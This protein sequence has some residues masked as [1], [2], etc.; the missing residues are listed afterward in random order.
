VPVTGLSRAGHC[1]SP[2][3]AAAIAA[4]GVAVL[5]ASALAP[6]GGLF[7]LPADSDIEV[8]AA[9]AERTF[10]G[11]VPYR[12]F[13]LE[14]P[15]GALPVLLAP[16]TS[17]TD[18]YYTRFRLAMLALAAAAVVLL[19][20]ALFRVGADAA[21]LAAAVLVLA[22]V[23]RTLTPGLV[24]DRFDL[25]PAV[26]VL[27]AVV[28][29]M[30]GRRTVGLAALGVGT[31]AKLYPLALVPLVLL[32]RRDRTRVHRDLAIVLG[33]MLAFALPFALLAPRG[34]VRVGWLLA[35]RELQVESLG[36]SILLAAHR[37]GVYEPKLYYSFGL[38]NSWDLEGSVPAIVAVVGSLAQAVALAAVWFAFARSPRGPHE[39]LLAVAASVVGFVAFGKVLSPQY[40]VWVLAAVPLVVGRVARFTLPAAVVAALLTRSLYRVGYSDLLEA[41]PWSWVVLARNIV[42][43][44][45]FA[46]L[47]LELVARSRATHVTRADARTIERGRIEDRHAS[48]ASR[49]QIQS[50]LPS[51]MVN[52]F[53]GT[54]PSE[55]AAAS[56]FPRVISAY[57]AGSKLRN[58]FRGFSR[59]CR[60]YAATVSPSGNV[61]R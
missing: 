40:M 2:R 22:T 16:A 8:Y 11:Q 20:V 57:G 18:D 59:S 1:T 37:L 52:D 12:D 5:V 60:R 35:R 14:Y 55:R 26:L 34:I 53:T 4:A 46:A 6:P 31:A 25:W 10:Q 45:I 19:V 24:L 32:L 36:A 47:V 38:G 51:G 49:H 43:V 29:V 50:I 58:A 30:Y 54:K 23:P 28:A 9:Y 15:P 41:G 21:Q 3:T 61:R 56:A 44:A 33:A 39:L 42:L 13:D 27:V 7:S 17:D 48:Q